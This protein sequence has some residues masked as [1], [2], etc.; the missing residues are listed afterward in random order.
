MLSKIFVFPLPLDLKRLIKHDLKQQ[1]ENTAP[2]SAIRCPKRR[3]SS[4]DPTPPATG[5]LPYQ[6]PTQS[7][8]QKC[9]FEK[10][11]KRTPREEANPLPPVMVPSRLTSAAGR[12]AEKKN[13]KMCMEFD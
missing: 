11:T 7:F 1:D 8:L 6:A 9:T 5:K 13:H 2:P 12:D 3:C 4:N 10:K